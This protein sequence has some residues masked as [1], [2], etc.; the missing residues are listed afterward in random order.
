M[1]DVVVLSVTI[2]RTILYVVMWCDAIKRFMLSVVILNVVILSVLA[3]SIFV[4]RQYDNYVESRGLRF[5]FCV[6][7]CVSICDL[8]LRFAF[9]ILRL[10]RNFGK[11]EAEKWRGETWDGATVILII[12]MA[13]KLEIFTIL[14]KI[15]VFT[16]FRQYILPVLQYCIIS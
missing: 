6:C 7:V 2:K 11:Q 5:T 8:N 4:W 9:C 1:L 14:V 16:N 12:I 10:S 13:E 15:V 3:P